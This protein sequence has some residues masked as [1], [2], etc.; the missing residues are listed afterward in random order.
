MTWPRRLV[1]AEEV[2]DEALRAWFE[3]I[4]SLAGAKLHELFLRAVV[5]GDQQMSRGLGAS[6][7][8]ENNEQARKR[9]LAMRSRYGRS[10]LQQPSSTAQRN[11]GAFHAAAR[12]L[13]L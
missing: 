4:R 9:E 1:S 11:K 12:Y 7:V 2:P 3:D 10:M 13:F 6:I 5:L 8:P